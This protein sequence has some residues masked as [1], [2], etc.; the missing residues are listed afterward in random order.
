MKKIDFLGLSVMEE[1]AEV[2]QAMSKCQKFGFHS[3]QQT[4]DGEVLE[5][6]N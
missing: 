3:R 1:C 6:T 2:A 5:K 4:A